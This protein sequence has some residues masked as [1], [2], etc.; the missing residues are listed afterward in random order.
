MK[1]II[2]DEAKT[3]K[4]ELTLFFNKQADEFIQPQADN[5]LLNHLPKRILYF[6][7]YG[8]LFEKKRTRVVLR[9]GIENISVLL[10]HIV[11]FYTKD[12]I[13]Y[14]IDHAGKKYIAEVNLGEL[15]KRLDE[16]TFFRANRQFIININFLKSFRTYE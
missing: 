5:I 14:G 15:E 1:E 10:E 2:L 4:D 9:K 16:G 13:V 6:D 7:R 3:G 11:F 8:P 12:K